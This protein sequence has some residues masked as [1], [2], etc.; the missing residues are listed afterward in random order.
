MQRTALT[1]T[2][3]LGA[4]LLLASPGAATPE[5]PNDTD[6]TNTTGIEVVDYELDVSNDEITV[7]LTNTADEPRIAVIGSTISANGTEYTVDRVPIEREGTVTYTHSVEEQ[8]R[9]ELI[10]KDATTGATVE[11][12]AAKWVHEEPKTIA[13]LALCLILLLGPVLVVIRRRGVR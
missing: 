10:V 11:M 2:V 3:L 1:T 6:G 7:V 12:I 13:G 4:L 5:L 8:T 9:E